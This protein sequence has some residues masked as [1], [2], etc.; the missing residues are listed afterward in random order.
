MPSLLD[1]VER[2]AEEGP[3]ASQPEA[4]PVK[5]Q[6][7]LKG[8]LLDRHVWDGSTVCKRCGA[9]RELPRRLAR[10]KADA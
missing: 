8:S 1:D 10:A 2:A 7:N 9:R 4:P 5:P 6:C 3:V